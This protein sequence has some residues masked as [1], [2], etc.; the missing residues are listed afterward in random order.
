MKHPLNQALAFIKPH[1][2]E[3]QK[4]HDHIAGVFKENG[5]SIIQSKRVTAEEIA[6]DNII[7]RHY[8][9]NARFG[10]ANNIHDLSLRD[11]AK[12]V[13]RVAFEEEWDTVLAE[14]RLFSG[15]SMRK[16]LGHISGEALNERWAG[17]GAHKLCG[18][19]Y[20]SFFEPEGSYV[21]NGFYPSIRE[22]FT[23]PGAAV[24]LMTVAFDM[25]WNTFRASIIGSTNPAA[26]EEQSIR[27]YMHDNADKFGLLPDSRDNI[28]HASASP[29]E[30]L[31]ESR[32]WL[33]KWSP[34]S[35]PLWRLIRRKVGM[36]PESLLGLLMEWHATN[37]ILT[38]GATSPA[39]LLD[40][41][42]DLDTPAVAALILK[43]LVNHGSIAT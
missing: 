43:L 23:R 19:C 6:A 1:A 14:G 20:V 3:S 34:S 12:E 38:I 10:T 29:F 22:Q 17:H 15:E 39:P 25:P 8:A 37:P 21:I 30:A 33:S 13:F 18:G 35:D 4:A 31:C 2:V 28:I 41:L 5:I 26:A 9:N 11:S 7:D 42:E 16:K 27:G 36:S 40:R 24:E 32:I